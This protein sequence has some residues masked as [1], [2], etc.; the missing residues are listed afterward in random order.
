MGEKVITPK[1]K[2]KQQNKTL[3]VQKNRRGTTTT[4]SRSGDKNTT[5]P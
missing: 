4:G 5:Q 3:I 1:T 2:E